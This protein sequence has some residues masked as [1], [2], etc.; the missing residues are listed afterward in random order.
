MPLY[1]QSPRLAP[2]DSSP[3]VGSGNLDPELAASIRQKRWRE[4]VARA[5]T[6]HATKP[7]DANIAYWLGIAELQLH[8]PIEAVLALRSA[9]KLGLHSALFHEGLGLAY[10]DLNQYFLFEKQMQQ[11]AQQDPLDSKPD[12][13]LGLYRLTIRSDLARA[14][15]LF[16][17]AAKLDPNDWKS[18][19]QEGNCLEQLGKLAD[20]R[21]RYLESI[22][23]VEKSGEHFGW[24]FQGMAR[25]LLND[26]PKDALDFATKAVNLEPNEP[27]NHLVLS[28]TYQRLG[29]LSDAIEEAQL[30]SKGNPTDA[31]TTYA[32]YKLYR[33]AR[34]PRAA[35]ELK[36]FGDITKLYG[37]N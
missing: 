6:L 10:Y 4:V 14:L 11:A 3:S 30:A 21:A 35:E 12:Y 22:H 32:L 27:S 23:L 20:A 1:A 31:T 16:A 8:Q 37:S 28:A 18:L 17:G 26:N 19:Y 9:E 25:L 13:Y 24:P 34:D 15:D 29:K 5:V 2:A 7:T 36:M 33:E